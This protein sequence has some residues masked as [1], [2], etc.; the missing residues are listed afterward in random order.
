MIGE[1]L[2]YFQEHG[3][4]RW[5]KVSYTKLK[6]NVAGTAPTPAYYFCSALATEEEMAASPVY[7]TADVTAASPR[8]TP[9]WRPIQKCEAV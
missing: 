1:N 8:C 7:A 6:T 9:R 5:I 4:P 2:T 3:Q